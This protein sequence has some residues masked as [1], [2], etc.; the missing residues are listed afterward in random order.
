MDVRHKLIRNYEAMGAAVHDSREGKRLLA[1]VDNSSR[2]RKM[3]ADLAAQGQVSCTNCKGI[4]R[5][6]LGVRS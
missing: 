2:K 5:H 4:R 1:D 3:E 6:P